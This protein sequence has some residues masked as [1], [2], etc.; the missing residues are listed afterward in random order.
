MKD[1]K[2]V[3]RFTYVEKGKIYYS[4]ID[5]YDLIDQMEH[6]IDWFPD[7]NENAKKLCELLPAIDCIKI[8]KDILE[9]QVVPFIE[10][11]NINDSTPRCMKFRRCYTI[12]W[13]FFLHQCEI[14]K[15][16]S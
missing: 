11:Q 12:I 6:M 3:I 15:K 9:T 16:N 13:S 1:K 4:T 2:N 10:Y 8:N 7:C 14:A 5:K